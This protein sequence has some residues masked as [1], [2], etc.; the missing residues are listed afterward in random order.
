MLLIKPTSQL[1]MP[2]TRTIKRYNRCM[3]MF[4]VAAIMFVISMGLIVPAA[5]K[6]SEGDYRLDMLL[7]FGIICFAFGLMFL[8]IWYMCQLEIESVDAGD[9][10]HIAKHTTLAFARHHHHHQVGS[11]SVTSS[12]SSPTSTVSSYSC[13]SSTHNV[14]DVESP[15]TPMI[16]PP[17]TSSSFRVERDT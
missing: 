2:V 7:Y 9:G 16:A 6:M 4:T 8:L 3:W 1:E 11:P 5:I 17:V 12:A 13:S 15:A 14:A 10:K